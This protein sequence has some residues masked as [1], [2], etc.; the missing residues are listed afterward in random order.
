[1]VCLKRLSRRFRE[2]FLWRWDVT[3]E[4]IEPLRK[5]LEL[6]GTI[7]ITYYTSTFA[8]WSLENEV[9]S[10]EP[11]DIHE[12][13]HVDILLDN[14][15]IIQFFER[16]SVCSGML[17]EENIPEGL[18]EKIEH[19]LREHGYCLENARRLRRLAQINVILPFLAASFVLFGIAF[20][21]LYFM[22]KYP[23]PVTGDLFDFFFP[24]SLYIL[25]VFISIVWLV[26]GCMWLYRY[27]KT[28]FKGS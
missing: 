13:N 24:R 26:D 16:K 6:L 5:D 3:P 23:S 11:S 7:D 1:M 21:K 22:H 2:T 19:I 8:R 12:S 20:M 17:Y 28:S 9:I 4:R 25:F 14:K 18:Q 15:V 10:S 27:K